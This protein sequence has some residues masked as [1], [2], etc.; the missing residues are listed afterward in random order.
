MSR[1]PQAPALVTNLSPACKSRI[2]T[3]CTCTARAVQVA[4]MYCFCDQH[5]T[6]CKHRAVQGC[7][8]SAPASQGGLSTQNASPCQREAVYTLYMYSEG[9]KVCIDGLTLMGLP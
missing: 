8:N 5:V 9:A 2:H 7:A 6:E 4:R 3:Q 1:Q